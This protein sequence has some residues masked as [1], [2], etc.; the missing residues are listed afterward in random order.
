[1]AK[2]KLLIIVAS[3]VLFVGACIG[4]CLTLFGKK[5]EKIDVLKKDM[6]QLI[7]V[8]GSDLNLSTLRKKK[9]KQRKTTTNQKRH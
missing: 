7:Y 1:M 3:A 6:P 2:K 5:V 8:Q 9:S 4:L